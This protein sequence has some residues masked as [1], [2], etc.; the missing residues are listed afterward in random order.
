M[1]K[2][3]GKT[4]IVT[5]AA[6]GMGRAFA[7]ALAREGADIVVNYSRSERDA[8]ETVRLVQAAGCQAMLFQ[9]DVADDAG[10]SAAHRARRARTRGPRRKGTRR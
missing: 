6:V 8:V 7:V 1:G 2:L 5:G 9:A 4:A 10:V 3:T